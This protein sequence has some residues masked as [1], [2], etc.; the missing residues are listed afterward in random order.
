MTVY[1]DLAFVLGLVIYG[2]V[3]FLSLKI[4]ELRRPWWQSVLCSVGCALTSSLA[5][6]PQIP[7]VVP[8]GVGVGIMGFIYRGK[9]LRGAVCN[10]LT[11]LV[12]LVLYLGLF[13]LFSGVIFHLSVAFMDGNGYFILPFLDALFSAFFS[14]LVGGFAVRVRQKYA[15]RPHCC[16]CEL[17]LEGRIVPFRCY[18]DTGNFL[19][20]ALSG[21][22]VV[23]VEYKIL[24]RSIGI[25]FPRPMTYEFALRFSTRARVI[26]YRSV[27]GEGQMLSA[28]VPE[29]FSVNGIPRQAVIAVTE[30][31]LEVRGRFSAIMGPVLLGGE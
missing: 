3:L 5:L 2:A 23:I 25:H 6:I 26:P 17:V 24:Q 28:F 7:V 4:L 30:R 10:F 15:A 27:S 1:P 13:F 16:N 20:D 11:G 18:V 19:T 8:L 9:T 31:N 22:P 12:V 29:S 14:F 21:L